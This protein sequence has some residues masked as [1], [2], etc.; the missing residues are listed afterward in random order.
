MSLVTGAYTTRNV[1]R[2][3]NFCYAPDGTKQN[4]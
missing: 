1:S 2:A 4:R 3:C